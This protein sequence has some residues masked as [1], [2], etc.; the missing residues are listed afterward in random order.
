MARVIQPML[1]FLRQK[2]GFYLTLIAGIPNETGPREFQLK[3]YVIT[4]V[5]G[6]SSYLLPVSSITAG[7][8]AGNV[9][10]PWHLAEPDAFKTQ[11][12][13][14]FTRFLSQT[15]GQR[16]PIALPISQLQVAYL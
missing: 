9:P 4:S 7:K 5:K 13:G 8:T 16:R 14:S 2:T 11:V 1:D 6:G 15:S 12:M 10:L 3:V